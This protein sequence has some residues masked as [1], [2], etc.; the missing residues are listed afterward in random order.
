MNFVLILK[1]FHCYTS[2]KIYGKLVIDMLPHF[3]DLLH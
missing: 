2:Q 1:F 3:N